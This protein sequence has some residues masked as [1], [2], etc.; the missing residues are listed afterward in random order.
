MRI[1]ILGGSGLIGHK[2]WYNLKDR[3]N[4]VFVTL[5]KEEAHYRRFGIFNSANAIFNVDVM[6][7]ELLEG[8]LQG[9]KADVVI[10]CIG[11]TKR[12]PEI[13]N[14]VYTLQVNSIYPHQLAEWSV[15][16]K[17]RLIHFSTDCVFNGSIGDYTEESVTSAEDMYGRSKALGELRYPGTLT[18]RSSFI[19]RELEGK[20]ELLEWFLGQPG[21]KVRGFTNAMYSGVSTTFMAKIVGDIIEFHPE[22]SGLYQLATEEPINKFD[23]LLIAKAA[24]QRYNISIEP[25]SSFVN[26]NTLDGRKL[27][28][29]IGY[30]VPRWEEMMSQLAAE[31]IYDTK[32]TECPTI[33]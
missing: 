33:G 17:V 29:I 5:H 11:I 6:R 19:G 3:F 4:D 9:L 20:T 24:F 25:D 16:N 26:I 21:P 18:I 13:N 30:K 22:L 10:N 1:I 32:E 28:R 2:L 14:T 12:K 27:Q 23:L 31:R 7:F 15:S 8:I